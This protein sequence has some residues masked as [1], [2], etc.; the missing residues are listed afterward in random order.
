M[1]DILKWVV[2]GGM[3]AVPFIV[4]IVSN[5][6]FFPFITGKNFTFRIIVEIAAAAW[7]LLALYDA[8]YRP[9]FSWV[10]ASVAALLVTMCISNIFGEYPLKSFWSNYERMDGYV[11]LVH[12]FLYFLLCGTMLNTDK[13]W[14]RFFNT[15][16]VVAT[17]LSLYAFAQ[18]S[19]TVSVSQGTAWRIDATFGNSTYMAVYMLFHI[20]IALL[21]FMRTQSRLRWFYGIMVVIFAF[22]LLQTG[23]R[24]TT[25]GLIGGTLITTAYIAFFAVGYKKLR[26]TA[27]YALI[28][29]VIAAL[30][31]IA[32]RDTAFVQSSPMLSRIANI[33]LSEGSVRFMVWDAAWQGVKERPVFGWGQENFSYVFNKFYKPELYVAET[34]YDRSHNIVM[35]WLVT[36]GFVGA[37]IYF[38]VLGTAVWYVAVRPLVRK[39]DTSFTVMERGVL[40]GLLAGYTIHNLFVFDNVVSYIFYAV[41]LG[42]IHS[43]V[44]TAAP[45]QSK[46]IDTRLVE[47]IAVPVTVLVAICIVYFVNVPSIIAAKDIIKGFQATDIDDIRANFDEALAEGGFADQEIREQMMQRVQSAAGA[48]GVSEESKKKAL[49]RV[50]EELLRQSEEK[51]GDARVEVFL[52]SFYRTNGMLDKA[53]ERLVTARALSPDKQIIIFEQGYTELQKGDTAAALAFF[54]EAYDLAPQY[55]DARINYANAALR[56][57]DDAL[58]NELISTDEEKKMYALNDQAV[59]TVYSVKHYDQLV[60]MFKIRIAEKPT[61]AQERAN[62]A[63]VYNEMGRPDEAID[64]LERAAEDIPSFKTQADQFIASINAQ[65]KA[66]AVP[67]AQ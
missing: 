33:S 4:F 15:N 54:K 14:T 35:D 64:I 53:T 62:L 3:F 59:Q 22:L 43:R 40:L 57:G 27:A 6:M 34:W 29:L 21:L 67:V 37:L 36:G 5:T 47:Q 2:Y 44:A 13:L 32:V 65:K 11:T 61:E 41:M 48:Q 16:I 52:A 30:A 8:Q 38:S 26:A 1:K 10:L 45:A 58:F 66:P 31:F 49:A 46:K 9:R 18:V 55:S 42:Y 51:P 17:L 20:V 23:T 56:A 24:G 63:Y 19:G 12:F 25:L 28:A 60:E 7:F 50:E 39:D